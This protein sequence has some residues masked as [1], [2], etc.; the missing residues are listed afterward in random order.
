MYRSPVFQR[1]TGT[2]S[3]SLN[4]DFHTYKATLTQRLEGRAPRLHEALATLEDAAALLQKDLSGMIADD[5]SSQYVTMAAS[6]LRVSHIFSY[7]TLV[8][9]LIEAYR[10]EAQALCVRVA[11]ALKVSSEELMG[12]RGKSNVL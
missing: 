7:R 4:P 6:F 1:P 5:E 8:A 3:S 9:D 2:G 10:P 12:G 11:S